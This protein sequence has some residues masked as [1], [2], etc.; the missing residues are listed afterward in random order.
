MFSL[1]VCMCVQVCGQVS[2]CVVC[3]RACVCL[4]YLMMCRCVFLSLCLSRGK[5]TCQNVYVYS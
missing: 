2:L 4:Y 5:L 1:H 3:V